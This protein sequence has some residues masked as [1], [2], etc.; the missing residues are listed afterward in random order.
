MEYDLDTPISAFAIHPT[1]TGRIFLGFLDGTLC[2]R[3]FDFN[4]PKQ[5]PK[6]GKQNTKKS[7]NKGK[8]GEELWRSKLKKAIRSAQFS[9]DGTSIY[10]TSSNK[11]VKY[12][13]NRD[14]I[15]I[16][17]RALCMFDAET[18]KRLFKI[19]SFVQNFE[20]F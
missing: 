17:C 10:V 12:F 16:N 9:P 11:F 8:S 2:C 3:N 6:N 15:F 4:Q 5:Q 14:F 20:Y 1:Q 18:G 19:K 13:L 7:S